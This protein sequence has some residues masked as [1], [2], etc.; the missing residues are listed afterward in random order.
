MVRLAS[1]VCLS[2]QRP[3]LLRAGVKAVTTSEFPA[4]DCSALATKMRELFGNGTACVG[5]TPMSA[6]PILVSPET[7]I[8]RAVP[9]L[10]EA[11]LLIPNTA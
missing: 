11:L 7:S 6:T 5:F 9:G 1:G 2:R 3:S 10:N 4:N 8:C